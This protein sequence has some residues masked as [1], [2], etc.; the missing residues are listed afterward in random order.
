[1]LSKQ[2]GYKPNTMELHTEERIQNRQYK[3]LNKY[4]DEDL[5]TLQESTE[6]H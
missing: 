4:S 6:V 3:D 1:M 2:L 5:L